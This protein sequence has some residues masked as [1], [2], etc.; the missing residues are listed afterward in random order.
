MAEADKALRMAKVLAAGGFPE[1]APALLAKALE[2][3]A[4]AL[5]SVRGESANDTAGA[6]VRYLVER[7]VLGAEALDLL[8]AAQPDA[9]LPEVATLLSTAGR[10][11]AEAARNEPKLRAV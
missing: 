4:A 5:M 10:I 2:K 7:N 3:T 8:D 11:L 1:E 9:A 6:D